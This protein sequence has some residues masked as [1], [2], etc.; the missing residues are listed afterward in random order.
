MVDQRVK[1]NADERAIWEKADKEKRGLSVEERETLKRLNTE[2]DA[3]R[4]KIEAEATAAEE[5]RALRA[6]FDAEERALA[7]S[8]GR[9]TATTV[10]TEGGAA[11]SDEERELA[12]KAW[13]MGRFATEEMVEAAERCGINHRAPYIDM[14][15]RTRRKGD[16][17]IVRTFVPVIANRDLDIQAKESRSLKPLEGRALSVG[18]TTAGGNAVPN[19]MMRAFYE[20][21]KWY[22]RFPEAAYQIDT[23]TG[24]TLPWPTVTDT[25]NTGRVLAEAT[26]ATTTTDPTFGVVNL[27][28]FKF[29]SDGVL[30][31]WEL[32]QD[33]FIDIAGYL[34]TAL[35]RRIGRIKN[36]K[37][38]VGAGTTEPAGVITKATV[39]V[40]AGTSTAFVFD[41]IISLIHKLD[42][43][44]RN[45]P[46]TQFMLH[47]TVAAAV[48]KFKDGQGRYLWEISAQVGQPDR[49]L[50]YPVLINNDMDS[51][52]TTGKKLV[53][54][55]NWK[56]A[57]IV[58]NAGAVRFVRADELYVKEHQ[59]YFEAS[60]RADG[61]LVDATAVQVLALA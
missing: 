35:G 21:Q 10:V 5:D 40:T 14:A 53:A 25:A 6:T 30:V 50:G 39:G 60:Q 61:N 57:Y 37:M 36:T 3:L 59:V 19:E 22:A 52:F 11:P 33:S 31:S 27:G 18:T 20:V 43:A 1:L 55:G 8:R 45:L 9:K 4:D 26:T 13:A 2:I 17:E 58:R 24:A 42:L 46:D 49:L 28:A 16:G 44:Y 38:T 23:E 34:G 32:L 51:A 54:F 41:D 7:E 56:I 47:D 12:F 48:R 15:C 29:S